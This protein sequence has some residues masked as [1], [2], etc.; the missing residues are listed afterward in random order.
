MSKPV[1]SVSAAW[2][3]RPP[4]SKRCSA[5]RRRSEKEGFFDLFLQ[6]VWCGRLRGVLIAVSFA[7]RISRGPLTLAQASTLARLVCG[8]GVSPYRGRPRPAGSPLAPQ[9]VRSFE[10]F[11][12]APA[13]HMTTRGQNE[14]N[15]AAPQ[16]RHNSPR[17]HRTSPHCRALRISV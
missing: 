5:C 3:P 2:L 10:R 17:P 7:S 6:R 9:C 14:P 16:P 11:H 8:H 12:L 4:A 15:A 1:G 13:Y